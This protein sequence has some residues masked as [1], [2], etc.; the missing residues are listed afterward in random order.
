ME[1][2]LAE[3]TKHMQRKVAL[4]QQNVID[5]TARLGVQPPADYVSF[6][7]EADG[8]EGKVG[9]AGY[10]VLWSVDELA[11][12]N[13]T[14]HVAEFAPDLVLFGSDGG[15]TAYAFDKRR[16]GR[17]LSVPFIGM[18]PN[19]TEEIG[20]CLLSLLEHLATT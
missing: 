11:A 20:A 16:P 14:Y 2:A 6:M 5:A 13:E 1:G 10:L 19:Q 8:A 4:S 17:V 3:L 7:T 18:S 12:L 9:N 15:D